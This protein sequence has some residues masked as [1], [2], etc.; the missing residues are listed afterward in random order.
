N[1]GKNF[2]QRQR[3]HIWLNWH[4][5]DNAPLMTILAY[6]LVGHRVWRRAEISIFAAFPA[7][8]VEEQRRRFE[9]MMEQGR[10]QIRKENVRFHS[11]NDGATYHSLVENAS[12]QA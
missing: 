1:S 4:D 8:E 11:V 7:A 12:A 5:S 10:I 6:I 3:I 9:V 2:G